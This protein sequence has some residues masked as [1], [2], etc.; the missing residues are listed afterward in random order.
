MNI[1]FDSNDINLAYTKPSDKVHPKL[2][3]Q[4]MKFEQGIYHIHDKFYLAVG[5]G[6]ANS[7]MAV[8]EDSVIIIDT[9]ENIQVGK[10]I[11]S[12]FRRYTDLPVSTII[13][14]H[15]HLDHIG[16]VKAFVDKKDVD[17]GIVKIYAH[18]TLMDG[19]RNMASNIGDILNRRA[20]Y[21]FGLGLEQGENGQIN[22]SLGPKIVIGNPT[23]IPP[24]D[25]FDDILK[26]EISGIKLELHFAP[27]ETDNEIFIYFPDYDLVQSADI[28]MGETYP[29]LYSIR[30]T[31]HRDP[32]KWYESIDMI[33]RLK[34]RYVFPSHGRPIEGDDAMDMLTSYRD[35]IQY[36]YDQTIRYM[37]KGYT[38]DELV[39]VLPSLP[40]NL[41]YHPWL[42][43]LYGTVKHS[44]RQIYQGH[45]GWFNGDPT[46]L[47]PLLQKD[48]ALKYVD[49]MGGRDNV[50][51]SAKKSYDNEEY[52][53]SAEIL[54]Y[55]ININ[56]NDTEA[57]LLKSKCLK[58]IGY[59]QQNSN[60]RNWY[61]T[62]SRELDDTF[63]YEYVKT[64]DGVDAKDIVAEIPI[65]MLLRQ[66][67]TKLDVSKTN[68]VNT[69][70][71]FYIDGK[72]YSLE[73]RICVAE[74]HDNDG[75]K[76]A[77]YIIV[78]DDVIR[79][80]LLRRSTFE[81]ENKRGNIDF[82]DSADMNTIYTFLAYFDLDKKYPFL[83]QPHI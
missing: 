18:S 38:P 3:E 1:Q 51:E 29:N 48:R 17:G 55:L 23:F 33:R 2:T 5:Y 47:D 36:T 53:W 11:L 6:V 12:D 77:D 32:Q 41:K 74:F 10:Q 66:F 39:E 46:F 64:I 73:I 65:H 71:G 75:Y 34:P 8:G 40:N 31:K 83:T 16:G 68:N 45:L 21:S 79:N 44:V 63:D 58:E 28:I 78:R 7:F 69:S 76:P 24:T 59:K 52:R 43:E 35:A 57:K 13:Y 56:I 25:T 4:S 15:N 22:D 54:T 42:G 62:A 19:I 67:C 80:V 50:L 26:L 14:T 49:M 72:M 27:S 9:C 30:G 60:W 20:V 37:N 82:S 70:F 81:D 61:I